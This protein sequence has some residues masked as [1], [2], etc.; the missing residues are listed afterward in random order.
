MASKS[1]LELLKKDASNRVAAATRRYKTQTLQAMFVRKGSGIST[2]ALYGAL[3]RM[4]IPV[5]I[6]GFP[7][8]IGVATIA[9]LTE[10]LT[11]GAP[12]AIAAGV[13]DATTYIY[14]ERAISTDTII[15][16]HDDDDDD[17]GGGEI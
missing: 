4:G 2:S 11:K 15:A 12:Q 16:G 1:E 5:T 14:I 13:G 9:L 6:G 7:W 8:K 17:E 3:N 10:G